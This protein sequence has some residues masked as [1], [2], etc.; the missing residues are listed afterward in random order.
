MTAQLPAELPA[1]LNETQELFFRAI[2]WPRGVSDFLEHADEATRQLFHSVFDESAAFRRSERVDIYANAY[3][4]R[5]LG[6]LQEMLPRLAFLCEPV[7]FH[8]LVTDYVLAYPS[9]LPD[10]RRLADRLPAFLVTH[11]LGVQ[12]PLLTEV[13]RVELALSDALD[14]PDC[15]WVTS[16]QLRSTSPERWPELKFRLAPAVRLV[17]L[18]YGWSEIAGHCDKRNRQAALTV[19]QHAEPQEVLVGRRGHVVYVRQLKGR[20]AQALHLF[21]EGRAF[22][23]TCEVMSQ[24]CS[25]LLPATLVK[26]LERWLD[27]QV[28]CD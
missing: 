27:R 1:S 26:F 9:E 28:L 25:A 19:V 15:A 5:L 12:L 8:N 7:G 24:G 2:T 21:A 20:E 6:A 14:A 22:G 11:P 4:H 18:N 10:L 17:A 13:A 16:E 23:E 3:F